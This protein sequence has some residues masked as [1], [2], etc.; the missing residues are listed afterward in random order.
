MDSMFDVCAI[1]DGVVIWASGPYDAE[2]A[3]AVERMAIMRQGCEDQFFATCA[4]S[5]YKEGD[6]WEGGVPLPRKDVNP[7]ARIHKIGNTYY[8]IGK[9]GL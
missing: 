9:R 6:K 8:P 3:E 2:N 1:R 7:D 4:P 5:Q